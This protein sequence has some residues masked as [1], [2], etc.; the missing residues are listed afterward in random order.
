MVF[1]KMV[2]KFFFD[3]M[4]KWSQ[5]WE[6]ELEVLLLASFNVKMPENYVEIRSGKYQKQN[7]VSG[8]E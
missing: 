4:I 2:R 6:N 8:R 3:E 1:E 5:L 7:V